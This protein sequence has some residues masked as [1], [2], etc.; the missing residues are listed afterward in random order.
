MSENERG[1]GGGGRPVCEKF[2]QQSSLLCV[3]INFRVSTEYYHDNECLPVYG[4]LRKGYS[5]KNCEN[6]VES[7]ISSC[8]APIQYRYRTMYRLL[9]TCLS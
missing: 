4:H 1:G 6:L 9:W 2:F 5:R 8:V 7:Y 3:L